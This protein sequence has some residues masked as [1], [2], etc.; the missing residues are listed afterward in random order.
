MKPRIVIAALA[1]LAL[2]SV[3]SPTAAAPTALDPLCQLIPNSPACP[4]SPL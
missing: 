1:F 2:G 3:L 4:Q